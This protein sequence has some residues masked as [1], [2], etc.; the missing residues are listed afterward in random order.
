MPDFLVGHHLIGHERRKRW[1]EK[2]PEPKETGVPGENRCFILAA[3]NRFRRSN[4]DNNLLIK[5]L[6]A[7]PSSTVV[8]EQGLTFDGLR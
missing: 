1:H 6:M 5:D 3:H 7:S 4:S 8:E 2:R